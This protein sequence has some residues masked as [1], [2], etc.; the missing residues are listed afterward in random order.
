M[1]LQVLKYDLPVGPGRFELSIE[2][3][4]KV[5]CVLVQEVDRPVVYVFADLAQQKR[6]RIFHVVGTGQ[7]AKSWAT[8]AGTYKVGPYYWHVFDEGNTA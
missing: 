7:S 6:T 4:A 5:L 8:Y 3:G 1:M 2:I